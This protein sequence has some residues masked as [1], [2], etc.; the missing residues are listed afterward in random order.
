MVKFYTRDINDFPEHENY[1]FLIPE[2]LITERKDGCVTYTGTGTMFFFGEETAKFYRTTNSSRS[3]I[4][5]YPIENEEDNL[6]LKEM[7]IKSGCWEQLEVGEWRS[8]F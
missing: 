1:F 6:K 3:E 7:M 2:Y 5:Y 8:E 4:K